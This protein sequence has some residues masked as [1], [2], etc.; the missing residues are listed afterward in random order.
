MER[1]EYMLE[2]SQFMA[3]SGLPRL[4]I[5]MLLVSTLDGLLEVEEKDGT[6]YPGLTDMD[7][8]EIEDALL[9]SDGIHEYK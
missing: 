6:T 9:K 3:T 5:R 2:C 8:D 7:D 4:D 1:I